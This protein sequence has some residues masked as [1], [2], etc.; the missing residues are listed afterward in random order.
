MIL[1]VKI[2][3]YFPVDYGLILPPFNPVNQE[4]AGFNVC[5]M[6]ELFFGNSFGQPGEKA[7]HFP[8]V[9]A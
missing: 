6:L 5:D 7:Q 2:L 4:C 9:G 3:I 1:G 8:R